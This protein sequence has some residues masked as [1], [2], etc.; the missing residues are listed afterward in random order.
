[1]LPLPVLAYYQSQVMA[2][3]YGVVHHY[4]KYDLH[5]IIEN[6]EKYEKLEFNDFLVE[7]CLN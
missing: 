1:M 4:Q 6:L 5:E 3:D 2:Q 7:L